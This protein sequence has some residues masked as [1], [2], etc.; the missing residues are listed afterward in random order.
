MCVS[1]QLFF[2]VLARCTTPLRPSDLP[3]PSQGS[4]APGRKA[5]LSMVCGHQV[6][7]VDISNN[8]KLLLKR[9]TP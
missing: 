5:Q 4:V 3:S 7:H 2:L 9:E 6:I 1:G 8:A